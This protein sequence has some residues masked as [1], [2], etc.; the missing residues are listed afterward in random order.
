MTPASFRF[1]KFSPPTSIP[2]R[3]SKDNNSPIYWDD[4]IESFDSFQVYYVWEHRCEG[5]SDQLCFMNKNYTSI[6]FKNW[7]MI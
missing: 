1:S 6:V 5:Y 7:T 4:T 3:F 2:F